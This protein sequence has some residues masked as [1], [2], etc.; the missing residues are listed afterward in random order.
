MCGARFVPHSAIVHDLHHAVGFVEKERLAGSCRSLVF[1][2]NCEMEPLVHS[3][4]LAADTR[5]YI[6]DFER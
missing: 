5:D 1:Q 2:P 3:L 6:G 4:E